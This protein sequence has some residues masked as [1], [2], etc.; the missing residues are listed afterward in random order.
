MRPRK[1]RDLVDLAVATAPQQFLASLAVFVCEKG[2][3]S[4]S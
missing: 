3:F 1:A 2:N 4:S